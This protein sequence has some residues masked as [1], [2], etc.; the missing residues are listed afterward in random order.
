MEK[1]HDLVEKYGTDKNISGYTQKYM[2]LWEKYR[3]DIQSV[4][5][6][7]VG[8][9]IHGTPFS[10]S[11]IRQHYDH[12][13]PGG[14][15]KVW[16][17]YFPNANI[18]G[19]DINEDCLIEEERLKTFIVSST[20]KEKCDEQLGDLTFDIIIDDANHNAINQ[21]TTLQHFFHR[22]NDNGYYVIEDVGWGEDKT[23][24]YS[25]HKDEV[26]KVV[27]ANDFSMWR[28]LI[29]IKKIVKK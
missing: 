8:T 22:V 10:F 16:R 19:I 14:S 18:Y 20:D 29:I 25:V 2:E 13:E 21:L 1:L 6:L 23:H 15:L 3:N 12:Y 24:L 28:T 27:G 11:H 5:E 26:D 4:L 9:L 17:D 7:G